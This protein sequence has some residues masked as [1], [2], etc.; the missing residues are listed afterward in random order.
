M[1]RDWGAGCRGKYSRAALVATEVAISVMLLA[2]TGLLVRTFAALLRV[3]PGFSRGKRVDV[4]N[5]ARRLRNSFISCSSK[6]LEIPGVVAA[7]A[8]SH[9]PLDAN[10]ANW[11]DGYT[12]RARTAGSKTQISPTTV[13]SCPDIFDAIGATLI[14]GR[15]FTDADD[16]A[17]Q[18][19]AIIDDELAAREWPGQSALGKT[20]EHLRLT[21]GFLRI[22]TRLGGGGRRGEARA[23]SFTRHH[24]YGRR[25]TS[26]SSS[27]RARF[28][29]GEEFRFRR[30][31]C[32]CDPREAHRSGSRA[33]RWPVVTTLGELAD[34]ARAQNR[35]VAYLVRRWP[36]NCAAA[37]LRG[38]CGRGFVQRRAANE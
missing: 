19:V 26:R 36:W 16:A 7:S 13:R 29:R 21:E 31:A 28:F 18:H 15:D 4:H 37:G 1:Q 10:Y 22:R 35:F 12:K 30:A 3:N 11:Y 14:A 25:F 8:S 38:D 5:H 34:Q 32:R 23:V 27:P 20:I 24:V 6:L 33:R 2:A 17:H 9:L